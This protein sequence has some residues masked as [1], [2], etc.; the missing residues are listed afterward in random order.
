MSGVKVGVLM[1]EMESFVL[2]VEMESR[3]VDL[4]HARAH[5][6]ANSSFTR[7]PVAK[8]TKI[9]TPCNAVKQTKRKKMT[10]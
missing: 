4:E 10:S 3:L 2:I 9:P 8:A 6:S 5:L 7:F 1:V